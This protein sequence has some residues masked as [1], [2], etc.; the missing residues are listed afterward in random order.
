MAG[1]DRSGCPQRLRPAPPADRWWQ[2]RG[3]QLAGARNVVLAAGAGEQPIVAD[4]ME[5][6]W[7]NMEQEA[8]DELV[9]AE[10]HSAVPR[11]AVA[12]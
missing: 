4:A 1:D 2:R 5:T 6:L 3:D 10:R 12:A 7:Q 8:P 9:G 11:L